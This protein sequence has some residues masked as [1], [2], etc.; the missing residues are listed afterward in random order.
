M[1][2][3]P[4]C[5]EKHNNKRNVLSQDKIRELSTSEENPQWVEFP[6]FEDYDSFVESDFFK[7]YYNL[8]NKDLFSS[9]DE[10]LLQRYSISTTLPY[11]EALHRILVILWYIS[12]DKFVWNFCDVE[13]GKPECDRESK[14]RYFWVFWPATRKAVR[15]FQSDY[16]I[17]PNKRVWD[18]TKKILYK[19]VFLSFH[20]LQKHQCIQD[21]KQQRLSLIKWR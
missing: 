17:N 11:T 9:P 20:T 19:R 18:D 21:A 13:P 16:G 8:W 3:G 4:V 12:V 1:K 7:K 6:Y 2:E 15:E 14:W 10:H 5:I